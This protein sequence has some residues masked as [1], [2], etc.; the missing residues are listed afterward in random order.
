MAERRPMFSSISEEEASMLRDIISSP[1]SSSTDGSMR[2]STKMPAKVKPTRK[3][4]RRKSAAQLNETP[5]QR[6]QRLLKDR[7]RKQHSKERFQT[8]IDDLQ[9]TV[10]VLE[11]QLVL[12][13]HRKRAIVHD[14]AWKVRALDEKQRFAHA[15][16]TRNTLFNEVVHL[17]EKAVLYKNMTWRQAEGEMIIDPKRDPWQMHTLASNPVQR[18]QH[19]RAIAQYQSQKLTP[20]LFSKFPRSATEDMIN[21]VLDER[22]QDIAYMEVRKYAV[23]QA[24]YRALAN[25]IF[26]GLASTSGENRSVEFFGDDLVISSFPWGGVV[27]RLCLQRVV[28]GDRVFLMHRSILYDETLQHNVPEHVASWWVFERMPDTPSGL[29][30]CTLRNYD[31][32]SVATTPANSSKDYGLFM[33]RTVEN[34][35]WTNRYLAARFHCLMIK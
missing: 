3:R 10:G 35:E 23:F 34:E 18:A 12:A 2:P 8:E 33:R 7:L 24:D 25:S 22:G 32:C 13:H 4:K 9:Q 26:N 11:Q 5:V 27:R 31:Q 19:I 30:M 17:I 28:D 20:T 1:R 16:Q 14:A 29:P 21:L 6:E 15:M